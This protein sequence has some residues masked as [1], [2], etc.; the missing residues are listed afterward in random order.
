MLPLLHSL[1]ALGHMCTVKNTLAARFESRTAFTPTVHYMQNWSES[2]GRWEDLYFFT[3]MEF[4]LNDYKMANWFTSTHPDCFF[5]RV[6]SL[7]I[8]NALQRDCTAGKS[9]LAEPSKYSGKL[10]SCGSCTVT[11]CQICN[12]L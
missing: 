5:T 8:S 10:S 3:E 12:R 2:Q 11:P 4:T 1:S 6:Q 7:G 9:Q